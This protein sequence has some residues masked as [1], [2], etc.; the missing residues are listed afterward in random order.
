MEF[1]VTQ[2]G[3][4][5]PLVG[6]NSN[7]RYRGHTFH[8]QTEDSGRTRPHVT[9]LLFADGGHIIASRRSDYR[10]LLADADWEAEVKR[11]MQ[12]Q[13]RGVVRELMS[14]GLDEK[15]VALLGALAP[16]SSHAHS[17][18]RPAAPGTESYSPSSP[19][20]IVPQLKLQ[21]TSSH[22]KPATRP[23]SIFQMAQSPLLGLG[24]LNQESLNDVI[25]SFI[26][27]ELEAEER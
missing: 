22:S 1:V 11:C 4:Q 3:R 7:V 2:R 18:S 23:P 5:S 8:I 27:Q 16:R 12:D 14:G 6:F 21:P 24:E 19:A 10:D 17:A 25:L 20:P 13:H 26:S 15:I 9:T